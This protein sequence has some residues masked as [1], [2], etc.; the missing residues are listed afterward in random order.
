MSNQGRRLLLVLSTLAVVALVF[1]NN[2]RLA[3][4]SDATLSA[5]VKREVAN[6]R[7]IS[8]I[9]QI[10]NQRYKLIGEGPGAAEW[11]RGAGRRE[12]TSAVTEAGDYSL[13]ILLGRYRGLPY[14]MTV[15]A[16]VVVD[17]RG[18]VK[19]VKVRRSGE[20]T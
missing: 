7:G 19:Q 16:V 14:K 13:H 12:S 2:W 11:F 20:G 10:L 6:A 9:R 15:D 5:A 1:A 17:N 18:I 4:R 8:E 3:L